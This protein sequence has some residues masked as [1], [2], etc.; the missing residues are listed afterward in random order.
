VKCSYISPFTS[1]IFGENEYTVLFDDSTLG[2]K[3]QCEYESASSIVVGIFISPL[4]SSAS[5]S[6]ILALESLIACEKIVSDDSSEG[7]KN[8]I[9]NA[10]RGTLSKFRFFISEAYTERG[11]GKDPIDSILFSSISTTIM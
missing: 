2:D 4:V 6:I 10:M 5:Q 3:Y 8:N 7:S 9:S 11:N 1:F